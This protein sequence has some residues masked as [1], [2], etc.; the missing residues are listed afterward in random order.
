MEAGQK[1]RGLTLTAASLTGST[2]TCCILTLLEVSPGGRHSEDRLR[3]RS[4]PCGLKVAHLLIV[5]ICRVDGAFRKL[6][7]AVFGDGAC[8]LTYGLT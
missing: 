1:G 3:Q 7:A 2:W 5:T 6:L 8:R 4:E